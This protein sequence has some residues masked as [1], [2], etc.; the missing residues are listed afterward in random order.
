MGEI[1]PLLKNENTQVPQ[2]IHAAEILHQPLG[3]HQ[4]RSGET[5]SDE[6][7]YQVG[8]ATGQKTLH[9]EQLHQHGSVVLMERILE[10]L[11]Q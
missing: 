2:P 3:C 5:S 10:G 7:A 9:C 4:L 8:H 1:C 11:H 6:P